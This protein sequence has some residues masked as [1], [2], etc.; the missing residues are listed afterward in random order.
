MPPEISVLNPFSQTEN[1]SI[2]NPVHFL[3]QVREK[4][5]PI[6]LV[7]FLVD[8]E[9]VS[10]S[11]VPVTS[12]GDLHFYEGSSLQPVVKTFFIQQ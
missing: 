4:D 7:E 9:V 10:T 3:V 11:D 8:G 1:L 2:G 12:I 6:R 5:R